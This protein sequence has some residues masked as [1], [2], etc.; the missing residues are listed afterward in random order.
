MP[1]SLALFFGLFGRSWKLV[2]SRRKKIIALL[3]ILALLVPQP[4]NAQLGFL[5]GLISII[6]SGLSA[7][8]G[9]LTSLNNTLQNVIG[10]SVR[11]I[12]RAMAAIQSIQP[13]H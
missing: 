6:S 12:R 8:S 4:A 1:A 11:S 3:V 13:G 7:D 5:T 9:I 2:T 10:P